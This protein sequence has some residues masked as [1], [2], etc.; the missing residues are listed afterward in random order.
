M[1]RALV[2]GLAVAGAAAVRSLV[3]HGY[4]VVVADDV[5]TPERSEL[6]RSLDVEIIE[7]PAELELGR[8]VRSCVLVCPSPGVPESHVVVDAAIGA[9]VELV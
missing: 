9:G 3:R 8:L 4:D 5:V 6:A 1:T 7:R 2:Y